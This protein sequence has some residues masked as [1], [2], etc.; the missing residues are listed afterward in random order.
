MH[1]PGF[2]FLITFYFYILHFE[3]IRL[4]TYS[5]RFSLLNVVPTYTYSSSTSYE[6]LYF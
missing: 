6:L 4:F 2:L 1:L 5:I 3:F